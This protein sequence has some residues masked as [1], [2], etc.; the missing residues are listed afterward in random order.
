M[1]DNLSE[2]KLGHYQLIKKLGEGG[3]GIVYLAEDSRLQRKVAIKCLKPD[4][5]ST[6]NKNSTQDKR[7][8]REATTLAQLNHPNVVQIYDIIDDDHGFALVMEYIEGNTLN[9][10]LREHIVGLKQRLIWLQQIADGLAAAHI[11]GLIH[12]DLKADNI[13]ING[14]NVAK[15]SDFGIAKNTQSDHTDHTAT[16]KFVGSYSALSP[17]QALGQPLDIRSDLFSFGILAFTLLCGRHPFGNSENHNVLVQNILHQHPLPAKSLNIGLDDRLI[18]MLNHMLMKSPEQRPANALIISQQLQQFINSCQDDS[19]NSF[20]ETLDIESPQKN[21][22][23]INSNS[24]AA[25]KFTEQLATSSEKSIIGNTRKTRSIIAMSLFILASFILSGTAY[26]YWQLNTTPTNLYVAVLPPVINKDTP[27]STSQQQLLID[28]ISDALQQQIISSE[29]LYLINP[30]EIYESHGDYAQRAKAVAA[31][32]LIESV[33]EC[34]A[35]RC[36]IALTRIQANS[37]I[38][39][40]TKIR[41]SVNQKQKWPILIDDHFLNTATEVQERLAQLFPNE[42]TKQQNNPLSESDYQTFLQYRRAILNEGQDT[43]EMWQTLWESKDRYQEYLPYYQLMSYLGVLLFDDSSDDKY[44]SYLTELLIHGE[45]KSGPN[46]LF[47]IAS[48]KVSLRQ[49]DFNKSRQLLKKLSEQ[50]VDTAELLTYQGLLENFIGN[51]QQADQLYRQALTLRPSTAIWYRIANNHF[52]Q[53]DS[54]TAINALEALLSLDSKDRNAQILMALLYILDGRLTDAVKLY[55]KLIIQNPKSQFYSNLGFAYE[56]LGNF[57]QAEQYFAKAV[58]L[59]PNNSSWRL[60]LAGS[61]QLQGRID[62]ANQHYHRVELDEKL[63]TNDW[64]SQKNLSEAQIQLGN[65]NEA[66][67][68]L[69][70]SL[71]LAGDNA[72]VLFNA[73]LVYT[74]SEQWPVAL[75]YVE[76]SLIQGLSTTWYDLPWF[77][78]L[79]KAEPTALNKLLSNTKANAYNSTA[80]QSLRCKF[81][82]N[83]LP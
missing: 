48:L 14:H 11:K 49:Q 62:E 60:N 59:S 54:H 31:D 55:K 27:M 1:S 56:L 7:L 74:L 17:E 10:Q 30:R 4:S 58:A 3:M 9:K 63:Q 21:I 73:A 77:D 78:S 75:S 66:F 23:S 6:D 33:L 25:A 22:E 2:Q 35:Q 83:Q 32:V 68:A 45:K 28:T 15:I 34:E 39:K 12:R 70:R 43:A 50:E 13:L 37:S 52:H 65:T 80:N 61:I 71:R 46:Q 76:Q 26:W 29:D 38:D 82:H 18:N 19:E 64:I 20:S 16:D 42:T 8:Q 40:N 79:C 36:D 51:Y 81:T 5:L 72:E 67:K 53:G 57:K 24:Q 41:W 47:T 44:L 69:H